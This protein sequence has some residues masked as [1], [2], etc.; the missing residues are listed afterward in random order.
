MRHEHEADI[1]WQQYETPTLSLKYLADMMWLFNRAKGNGSSLFQIF[2]KIIK[3]VMKHK[4]RLHA[5]L[6]N[7]SKIWVHDFNF[8]SLKNKNIYMHY[9][10]CANTNQVTC[11][12]KA[13]H[14]LKNKPTT[15]QNTVHI[16]I[17][18]I[19]RE[20][21]K[22]AFV[23]DTIW[24]SRTTGGNDRICRKR[25]H[26]SGRPHLCRSSSSRAISESL[27]STISSISLRISPSFTTSSLD[28]LES[29]KR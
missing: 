5:L 8:H 3:H 11:N 26:F 7:V 6:T 10:R 21:K 23:E 19:N 28:L 17:T 22:N 15:V 14:L 29:M 13:C 9:T 4:T 12:T 27:C 20:I 24:K 16:T 1:C 18:S 25:P 2:I